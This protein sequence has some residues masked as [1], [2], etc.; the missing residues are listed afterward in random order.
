MPGFQG[1]YTDVHQFFPARSLLRGGEPEQRLRGATIV[2]ERILEVE[3]RD[4]G[5]PDTRQLLRAGS[6]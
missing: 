4:P 6:A 3:A 5:G 2:G 1:V